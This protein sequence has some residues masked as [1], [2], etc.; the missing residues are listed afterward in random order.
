MPVTTRDLDRVIDHAREFGAQR[1]IL[2]GS[3]L[4]SPETARDLDI[5]AD[6]PGADLFIFAGEL[7]HMLAMPVDVIPLDPPSRFSRLVERRGRVLYD[8][9]AARG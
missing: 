5:G 8:A 6:I 9:H 4:D 7:E 3:A 1:V 2:F